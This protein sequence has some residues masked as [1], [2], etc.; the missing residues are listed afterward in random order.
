MD[1]NT[2]SKLLQ[3]IIA[4][5]YAYYVLNKPVISDDAYN[6]LYSTLLAIEKEHPEY[7]LPNSPT[8]SPGSDLHQ[9]RQGKFNIVKHLTPMLSLRTEV[10]TSVTPIRDFFDRIAKQN[11][12]YPH[13]FSEYKYDGVA[14]SLVYHSE[15]GCEA[16]LSNSLTRGDGLYGEDVMVNAE[17]V[18][19]VD[20]FISLAEGVTDAKLPTL[21]SI[22]GEVV[23]LKKY[24]ER[25]N[26]E[27]ALRGEKPYANCR[28]AAAGILRTFD[29]PTESLDMLVFIPY[30][31]LLHSSTDLE[32]RF[33]D[34]HSFYELIAP[35]SKTLSLAFDPVGFHASVEECH[36][37]YQIINGQRQRPLLDFD[38]DG[39]VFKLGYQQRHLM[40]QA[41]GREPTWAF[42]HKFEPQQA[43]TTL[44]SIDLQVGRT[45]R[46]TP[47][48]RIDPV[49]VGGAIVGSATL[50]NASEISRL[51]IGVGD[52][53]I[54]HRGGDVIP[55]IIGVAVK[56]DNPIT[57]EMPTTCPEC[58]SAV[59]VDGESHYCTNKSC[60]SRV[61]MRFEHF[62]SRKAMNIDE[63]GEHII[64]SLLQ[65]GLV[66]TVA[67][68]Y[69]IGRDSSES[70]TI[71][72][73]QLTAITTLVTKGICGSKTAVKIVQALEK[74]KKTTLPKFLYALG[75][76]Y[77]GEGTAKRLANH[78]GNL[79]DIMNASQA[80]LEKIP[81]I[82][83][84]TASSIFHFFEQQENINL[85]NDLRDVGVTWWER[86][87]NYLAK[88]LAGMRFVMTGSFPKPRE[89]MK[90]VLEENGAQVSSS[91]GAKTDAVFVGEKPTTAK[92]DKAKHLK[93]MLL[94]WDD[95]LAIEKDPQNWAITREKI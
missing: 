77:V 59:V 90:E 49:S 47:V 17:R 80:E 39:V 66:T 44:L 75:I 67:D 86:S 38:I 2:Y 42:A 22:R 8:Q 23:M 54:V 55:A 27:L 84:T 19:G 91:V 34:I 31:V 89:L 45:G 6:G 7:I 9:I 73:T 28:N 74:S 65:T 83:Q 79:D 53:V 1:K 13:V 41:S 94:G 62:V 14:L 95:F 43:V 3:T 16:V 85:V 33:E 40:P 72:Q 81:D 46:I 92:V 48:A 10:D 71:A 56:A 87:G 63:I 11:I 35:K 82:G 57:F 37:V 20:K 30:E 60:P 52:T 51:Q 26:A 70:L 15:D 88:P 61:Q 93:L 69:S 24:F 58:S 32:T 25:V 12:S 64:D 76:R 4:H 5:N 78:Y 18:L 29:C 36:T 21:M 50:H 68:L